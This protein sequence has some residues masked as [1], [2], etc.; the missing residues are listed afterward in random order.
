M[1][2]F[3]TSAEFSRKSTSGTNWPQ[4][5]Q[6]SFS[7]SHTVQ[8]LWEK[9]GTFQLQITQ[10]RVWFKDTRGRKKSCHQISWFCHATLQNNKSRGSL[11]HNH[12]V[13]WPQF[14]NSKQK[15][16]FCVPNSNSK[17]QEDNFKFIFN[18]ISLLLS[19]SQCSK[20]LKLCATLSKVKTIW[21]C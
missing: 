12:Q 18:Y 11:S 14:I 10:P 8:I 1:W 4:T 16:T 19:S 6:I 5:S 7:R 17:L 2:S 9:S 13:S 3:Q 21:N 20:T 15:Q